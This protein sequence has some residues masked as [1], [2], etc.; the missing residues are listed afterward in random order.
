MNAAFSKEA[1]GVFY[2][3]LKVLGLGMTTV[4]GILIIFYLLIKLLTRL[5]PDKE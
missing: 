2:E 5:F 3:G 1:F 4:I